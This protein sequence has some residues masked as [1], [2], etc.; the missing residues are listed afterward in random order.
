MIPMTHV[1]ICLTLFLPHSHLKTNISI[2]NA[3]TNV[4]LPLHSIRVEREPHFLYFALVLYYMQIFSYN[5]P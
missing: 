5:P 2:A 4:E 1:D 3:N